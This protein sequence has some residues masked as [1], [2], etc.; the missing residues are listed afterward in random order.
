MIDCH[1]CRSHLEALEQGTLDEDLAVKVRLHMDGCE[2][3]RAWRQRTQAERLPGPTGN[4]RPH[5]TR[6]DSI[7]LWYE[8]FEKQRE[9]TIPPRRLRLIQLAV[10]FGAFLLLLLG[11]RMRGERMSAVI[12]TP[13]EPESAGTAGAVDATATLSRELG[14]GPEEGALFFP[15]L[16]AYQAQVDSLETLRAGALATLAELGGEGASHNAL[17]PRLNARVDSLQQQRLFL[18][19]SFLARIGH[20]L[21][22]PRESRLRQLQDLWD[23]GVGTHR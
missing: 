8:R 19:S 14:L 2:F 17:I 21:G 20:T 9:S 4:G 6:M 13:G 1:T 5:N 12:G 23:R 3:C 18:R 10:I 15:L 11:I 16:F 22:P 7:T